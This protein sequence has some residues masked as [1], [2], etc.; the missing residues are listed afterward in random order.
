MQNKLKAVSEEKQIDLSL[1]LEQLT[2][3]IHKKSCF[4]S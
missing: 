2:W 4:P 1:P 3:I